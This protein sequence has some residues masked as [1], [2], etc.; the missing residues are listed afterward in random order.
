M[1]RHHSDRRT[2]TDNVGRLP[3]PDTSFRRFS[4]ILLG[5]RGFEPRPAHTSAVPGG[6]TPAHTCAPTYQ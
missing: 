1:S 5:R 6:V 4:A 2:W 3:K